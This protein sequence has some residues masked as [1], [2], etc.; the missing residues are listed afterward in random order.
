LT[1]GRTL[2]TDEINEDLHNLDT[3]DDVIHVT[4]TRAGYYRAA[5]HNDVVY[6][7]LLHFEASPQTI[8]ETH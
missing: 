6:R 5:S 1:D 3:S 2:T 7:V 4:L 8:P